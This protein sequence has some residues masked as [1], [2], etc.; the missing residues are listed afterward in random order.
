M[1]A[2][3]IIAFLPTVV[4]IGV[5]ASLNRDRLRSA[6]IWVGI[7]FGML[8][9][10][11]VWFVETW[12]DRL[13]N[14]IS[15]PYHRLFVVEFVG[16]GLGEE[17][18]VAMCLLGICLLYREVLADR[19][20]IVAAAV[21]IAI[22]F[23]TV[24]NI[25]AVYASE[26]RF[27]ESLARLL[28]IPAG[29]VSLQLMMGYFAANAILNKQH[30]VLNAISLLVIPMLIHGWGDIAEGLFHYEAA[31]DADSVR[32]QRFFS[33]WIFALLAYLLGAVTVLWKTSGIPNQG[34]T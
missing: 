6:Y 34:T 32:T 23:T 9:V 33:C 20:K 19:G 8:V 24:E 27:S 11:P 2:S 22:G 12:V 26:D 18:L 15:H 17:L 3:A 5:M 7:T 14:G 4:L 1:F 16:A 25:V 29:H 28:T 10:V 13:S 31:L 21:S 30:R